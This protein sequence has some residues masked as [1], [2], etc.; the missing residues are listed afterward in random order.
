MVSEI[1]LIVEGHHEVIEG[2]APGE[3]VAAHQDHPALWLLVVGEFVAGERVERDDVG[4]VA[5]QTVDV[6]F[7]LVEGHVPGGVEGHD[8]EPVISVPAIPQ[9]L[10]VLGLAVAPV[11]AQ[12]PDLVAR[13][14]DQLELILAELDG[15]DQ[16]RGDP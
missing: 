6:G 8:E 16:H 9:L 1:R 4:A 5:E 11:V 3:P 15:V 10:A 12:S 14:L 2:Y 13:P 7:Q